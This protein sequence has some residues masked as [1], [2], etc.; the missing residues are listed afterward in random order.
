M[1][2]PAPETTSPAPTTTAAANAPQSGYVNLFNQ[3]A[4]QAQTTPAA[5][6][7]PGNLDFLRQSPQFLQL[8]QMVQQRPELL[9]PLLQEIA[10]N[11]PELINVTVLLIVR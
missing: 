10:H 11:N 3:G 1:Q 8:R 5:A 7:G 9:Q 4:Q 6:T 2:T